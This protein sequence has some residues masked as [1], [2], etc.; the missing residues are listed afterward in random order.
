MK[1]LARTLLTL[2]LLVTLVLAAVSC[3]LSTGSGYTPNLSVRDPYKNVSGKITVGDKTL[4]YR[5]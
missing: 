3:D 4:V 1:H 5:W 2:L